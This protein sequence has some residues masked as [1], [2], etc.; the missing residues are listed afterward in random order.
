MVE[1][2]LESG[3]GAAL[4]WSCLRE[5]DVMLIALT[6]LLGNFP[7]FFFFRLKNVYFFTHSTYKHS[8]LGSGKFACLEDA[9]SRS[10]RRFILGREC[11]DLQSL[12]C[13]YPSAHTESFF[14][15][16]SWAGFLFWSSSTGCIISVYKGIGPRSSPA[17]LNVLGS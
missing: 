8:L 9:V 11:C 7:T 13:P 14:P 5:V 1:L 12:L 6:E 16:P 4:V 17:Q 10:R 15:R 3:L 2:W